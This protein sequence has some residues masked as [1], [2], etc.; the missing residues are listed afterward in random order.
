MLELALSRKTFSAAGF[1]L[2]IAKQEKALL[3]EGTTDVNGKDVY[4]LYFSFSSF[5]YEAAVSVLLM[6]K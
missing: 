4:I 3:M 1:L 5:R 2:P 6:S